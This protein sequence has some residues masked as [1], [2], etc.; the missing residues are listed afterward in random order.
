MSRLIAHPRPI[1]VLVGR[2]NVGK[3]T[4]FN[5]LTKAGSALVS[6]QPGTTRDLLTST[7]VWQAH[8]GT[9]VD[10]GG[11]GY[12]PDASNYHRLQTNTARRDPYVEE[13]GQKV[14]SIIKRAD[15]ICLIVDAHSGIT[16][17]DERWAKWLRT[18]KTPVTIVVNKADNPKLRQEAWDFYRLGI[19]EV[20][21]VSALNGSGTGD[22]LDH[23]FANTHI[24][25]RRK[26]S[27]PSASTT[28]IV[29]LGKPNVGKSTLFNAL[30]GSNEAIVSPK[31]HT[32][33]EPS[34]RALRLG[35]MTI[36]L[37]DTVG[38]RR[39][40]EAQYHLER[41][42]ALRTLKQLEHSQVAVLVLD[43]FLETISHQD[44]ELARRIV[45]ARCGA[46]I[47]INKIDQ[48]TEDRREA[49]EKS[50]RRFFPHLWFAPVRFVSA[51]DEKGITLLAKTIVTVYEHHKREFTQEELNVALAGLVLF[52]KDNHRSV[53]GPAGGGGKRQSSGITLEQVHVAPPEFLI[54][55]FKQQKT[56]IA[57][58][59]L[60]EKR[61]REQL[62]LE[63]TPITIHVEKV[64]KPIP[65]RKRKV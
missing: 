1:I 19:G 22:L 40:L 13:I 4:L 24:P 16:A 54:A 27:E 7:L 3:S 2:T 53:R 64:V 61:L 65:N 60:I 36:D 23:L 44:Q 30:S 25:T 11:L 46:V 20:C 58:I 26:S 8:N 18:I 41:V 29:L 28:A 43:P 5:R 9:L 45:E 17:E 31:A 35:G 12:P 34:R 32:T 21:M 42:G 37:Y 51:L 47:V 55:R 62:P 15:H 50:V 33:R 52:N 56:P 6:V 10:T 39:N 48:F 59:D 49:L 14:S 57:I 38:L 63:G